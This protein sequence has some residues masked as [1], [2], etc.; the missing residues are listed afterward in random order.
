VPTDGLG[1]TVS[2]EA[3][4]GFSYLEFDLVLLSLLSNDVYKANPDGFNDKQIVEQVQQ[5]IRGTAFKRAN[6]YNLA[7]PILPGRFELLKNLDL[8][9]WS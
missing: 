5:R 8:D 6:P 4:F 9:L 3:Q 7:H 2:D 1:I